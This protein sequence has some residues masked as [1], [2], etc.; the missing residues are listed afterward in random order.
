MYTGKIVATYSMLT[1]QQ[2][3][4]YTKMFYYILYNNVTSVCIFIGFL[5]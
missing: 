4:L 2:Y 5:L 3:N 1:S